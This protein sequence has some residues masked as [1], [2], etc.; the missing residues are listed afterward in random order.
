MKY[1]VEGLCTRTNEV[2]ILKVKADTPKDAISW[3]EFKYNLT[4][5]EIVSKVRKTVAEATLIA[6]EAYANNQPIFNVGDRK[7]YFC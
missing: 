2:V 3:A 5:C 7:R 1:T 6:R 4:N